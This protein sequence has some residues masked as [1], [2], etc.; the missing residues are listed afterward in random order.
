GGYDG[1]APYEIVL[2][3]DTDGDGVME[4]Q[5][6]TI[7]VSTYDE[8]ETT[9]APTVPGFAASVK[10]SLHPNP[11]TGS[12]AIEFTLARGVDATLGVYDLLGREVKMLHRGTLAAGPHRFDWTGRDHDGRRAPAVVYFVRYQVPGRS[13]EAKVVKLR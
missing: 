3:A 10:L 7:V 5:A 13:M 1:F 2:E 4:R 12:S 9:S 8:H 6:G 11:V